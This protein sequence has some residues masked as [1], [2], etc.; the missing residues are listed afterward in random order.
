MAT[1]IETKFITRPE[2]TR[3]VQRSFGWKNVDRGDF[4]GVAAKLWLEKVRA[5][6]SVSSCGGR[7]LTI[8]DDGYAWLQLA[9]RNAHWWL[10][11]M[12]DQTGTLVQCYFD[13][14]RQNHVDG[15]ASCFEDLML[16]VIF[17]PE[18]SPV[19]LDEDELREALSLGHITR[20]EAAMAQQEARS[21]ME[22][23]RLRGQALFAFCDDMAS[24][25]EQQRKSEASSTGKQS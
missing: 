8:A 16:D 23:L 15:R 9:P 14:T 11:A 19:L 1:H 22:G 24:Q 17:T 2:W 4:S 3:I 25:L 13:I 21:L 7:K 18:E 12:Y 20:E 6:L 5:P 10:T